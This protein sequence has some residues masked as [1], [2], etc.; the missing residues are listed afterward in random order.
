MTHTLAYRQHLRSPAW[1]RR[2]H[3]LKCARGLRCERCGATYGSAG[4]LQVHHRTYARLG[5]ELDEDLLVVCVRC[6]PF[7][8][9]LRRSEAEAVRAE[10]RLDGWATKVYGE[11]WADRHDE[12]RVEEAFEAWL[13]RR[14]DDDE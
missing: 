2:A 6:H 14:G 5:R 7:L 10:A 8:D 11:D 12:A 13:E 9:E 3:A 4:K 1:R